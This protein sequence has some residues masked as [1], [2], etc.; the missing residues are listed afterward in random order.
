[1]TTLENRPNTALLVIDMQ[2]NAV[3]RAHDRDVVVA[4]V[5]DLVE[6]A[7]RGGVP[8]VWIQHSDDELARGSDG[9]QSSPRLPQATQSRW[10]RRTMATLSRTPLLR[11]CCRGSVSGGWWWSARKP[12]GASA[13]RC[14]VP[15]PGV[16][17][18]PSSAMRTRRKTRLNGGHLRRSRSSR[19]R[20]CTG[21]TRPRRGEP[22]GQ[23]TP[24]TSTSAT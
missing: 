13:P 11:P 17:T 16:T 10:S 20:T 12:I 6:R 5:A 8:V 21:H 1:M 9:W 4:N 7:R 23:S 19:T 18:R 22:P 2:N 3:E 15:W 24:R 14:T